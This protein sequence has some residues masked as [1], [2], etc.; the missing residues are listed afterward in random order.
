MGFFRWGFIGK[1]HFLWCGEALYL[2]D[3]H[4]FLFSIGL[5]TGSNN[6]V[7]LLSIKYLMLFSLGQGCTH[8]QV[9]GYSFIIIN[10]MKEIQNCYIM[11]LDHILDEALEL[12][13]RFDRISF[14]HV[15]KE[16]N[17]LV[18]RISKEE[19]QLPLGSWWVKEHSQGH[20]YRHYHRPFI[21]GLAMCF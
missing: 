14:S 20:I 9:F 11:W 10:W 2:S 5:G 18:D 19:T 13:Q 17:G 3:D 1:S 6:Y 21:D 8:L 7:K 4:F 16:R 12:K 15:F